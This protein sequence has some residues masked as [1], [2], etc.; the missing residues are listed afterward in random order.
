MQTNNL[1]KSKISGHRVGI[2]FGEFAP[3]HVGHLSII[4]QALMENDCVVLAISGSHRPNDRGM[5]IDLPLERRFRYLREAF[6]DEPQLRIVQ[7][8]EDDMPDYPNGWEAWV[9]AFR[10]QILSV[11]EDDLEINHQFTIYAGEAEYDDELLSRLPKTYRVQHV[12]RSLLP[13]SATQIRQN[14]VKYWNYIVPAFRRHFV[15]KVLIVGSAS[16]GK[17]T[18]IRR[19]AKQFQAP[20]SEE[21]AR[22]YEEMYNVR[23]DELTENDYIRFINGQFDLNS[24]AIDS[25]YSKG[26]AILDTDAIVTRCYAK[27]YLPES[28]MKTLEPLFQYTIAKEEI[29]LILVL[30]PV[31]DYVDDGFRAMEWAETR[32]EYH[33]ELMAEL[34][35]FGL[36]D[37]VK[38]LNAGDAKGGFFARYKQ[39]EQA[40]EALFV[41]GKVER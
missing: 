30:P 21:H 37:K 38:I 34:Q 9:K 40:I 26:L 12:E 6:N 20:F 1:A 35:E 8:N 10:T 5:T 27:L 25:P 39:A 4:H 3:L 18:M 29:D 19:L 2:F 22:L 14:P 15:K 31:T 16:T 13:I 32:D 24:Q 17:S 41:G 36:M 33:E 28:A 11:L 23:D 7:I